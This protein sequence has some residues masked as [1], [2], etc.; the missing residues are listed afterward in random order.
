M[1]RFCPL[2]TARKDT[3]MENNPTPDPLDIPALEAISK[4][5][6]QGT[7]KFAGTFYQLIVAEDIDGYTDV[8]EVFHPQLPHGKANAKHI[9]TFDP[10]TTL[11]LL[12]ALTAARDERDAMDV[13]RRTTAS[14]CRA[15]EK[16]TAETQAEN[17][18]LKAERDRLRE[19]GKKAVHYINCGRAVDGREMLI[20]ALA[21]SE[22]KKE[23]SK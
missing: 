18:A 6:T 12:A 3:Q 19:V 2:D 15:L 20:A 4:A 13:E 8:A 11:K 14:L 1:R 16:I 22:A 17:A 10:P 9:A 23:G 21:A 7:W 5:A